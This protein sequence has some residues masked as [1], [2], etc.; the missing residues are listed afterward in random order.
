MSYPNRL[1]SGTQFPVPSQPYL[2]LPGMHLYP[3]FTPNIPSSVAPPGLAR[4]V[5]AWASSVMQGI[6]WS[7]ITVLP[8]AKTSWVSIIFCS[9]LGVC[10][11]DHN[12]T[13]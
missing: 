9:H 13:S 5:R 10:R 4:A 12:V 11:D 3:L 6:T 1:A 7:R 8:S 2:P